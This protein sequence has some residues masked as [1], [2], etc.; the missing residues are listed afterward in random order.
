[1]K[2]KLGVPMAL[3]LSTFVPTTAGAGKCGPFDVFE[4]NDYCV[5][6]KEGT[7]KQYS[8][9]GGEVGM[10][11]V[12]VQNP[13]CG[14]SYWSA[15]TCQATSALI[16]FAALS[17]DEKRKQSSMYNPVAPGRAAVKVDGDEVVIR[18]KRADFDKLV[19]AQV[20]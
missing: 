13:G 1:M 16:A 3:A 18:M 11:S 2:L 19:K 10:V 5:K 20:K 6:C 9:P 14:V 12:G 7:K 4:G 15:A 17:D 8:C